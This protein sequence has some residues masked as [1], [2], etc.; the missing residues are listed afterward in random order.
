[1]TKIVPVFV[2]LMAMSFLVPGS[3]LAQDGF[4]ESEPQYSRVGPRG[5]VR[6]VNDWRNEVRVTIWTHRRERI[7]DFWVLEPGESAFLTLDEDRIEVRPDYKIKVGSDWG[8]VDL[9]SVGRFRRGVWS[10]NV[11]D[12]WQATHQRGGGQYDRYDRYNRYNRHDQYD[13]VPD[14][15]ERQGREGYPRREGGQ[16]SWDDSP[17]DRAPLPPAYPVQP[18]QP[19]SRPKPPPPDRSSRPQPPVVQPVRPQPPTPIAPAPTIQPIQPVQPIRPQPPVVQPVRPQPPVVQPIRPQPT[20][21]I[22]PAPTMQPIQ[23]APHEQ[24]HDKPVQSAPREQKHDKPDNL[25]IQQVIP[26]SEPSK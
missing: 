8:W 5:V 17:R 11:R 13:S 16:R 6:V 25:Q 4:P 9:G 15:G 23:P 1:M 18:D 24:K 20:A 3:G 19:P 7:G 14:G 12:I 22:T 10:V 2:V 26:M 21:P